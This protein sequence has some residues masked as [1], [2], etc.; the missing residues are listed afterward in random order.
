[1]YDVAEIMRELEAAGSEQTRKTFARH[2][3]S[4]P[5]FGVKVADLKLIAKKI[6]GDQSLALQL[7]DTGNYDAMYLAGLVADGSLMSKKE[8]EHWAKS[9]K[10]KVLCG[11]TVA[12]VATESRFVL[13]LALKWIGA[14][15]ESIA[16]CGWST[17]AGL[18]AIKPDEE[19][20]LDEIR[21]L[22][23]RV[24]EEVH[25]APNRVRYV[26]VQFVISVGGYVRPLLATAKKVAESIGTVSVDHENT[27]CKTPNATEYINKIESMGR[28]GK[29]RKTMKC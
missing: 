9:T 23:D 11:Y 29:K 3:I 12:W 2:G 13:E 26:M 17:Y 24:A 19:L 27:D 21:T 10:C 6:R 5:M 8:L 28:I 18:V 4:I 14:K 25:T 1:M 16:V 15:S 22:L 20:D 7:Y